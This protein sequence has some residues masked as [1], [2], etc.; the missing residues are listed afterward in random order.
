M[1]D[2]LLRGANVVDGTGAPVRRAHVGIRAG[3]I[4]AVGVDVDESAA[5]TLDLDGLVVAPGFVDIHTHYD[6]QVLWD[7]LCTPSPLH[8]VTTVVG[9]NCGFTIAPL[10]SDDD[11]EYVMRMM[12]RVEGMSIGALR[13]GPSW[14]WRTFGEWL[15]RLDG[16]LGINAGF[17]VGHSTIRRC[18]MGEAATRDTA[19]P[20]QVDAMVEL[21]HEAMTSG[22]LGLSSS[23]GEAHT[24]GDGNPVPSRAAAR[25][26]LLALARAVRDHEGTT[27]EFIPAVGTISADRIELM[28]EMSLAA[29]RPLNWNLLGSLSPTEIYEQQLTSCDHAAENGAYVVALALPTSCG[30]GRAACSTTC[31]D[32]ARSSTSRPRRDVAPWAIA[33][34]VPGCARVSTRRSPVDSVQSPTPSCSRSPTRPTVRATSSDARSPTSPRHGTPT[35]STS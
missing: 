12:A 18:V 16:R 21:A 13:A 23:Y 5:R 6:A 2:L 17:L 1:L 10:G 22:A 4:V 24:D 19:T 20:A 31:P 3:R 26:E 32:G 33:R 9:G 35:R 11:V 15:D 25:D 28:T 29:N 8:G 14:D 7:P 30:C 34:P 27:L